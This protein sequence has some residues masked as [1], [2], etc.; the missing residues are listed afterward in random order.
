MTE[1]REEQIISRLGNILTR[2][3]TNTRTI[4]LFQQLIYNHYHKNPRILPWRKTR[5]PYKILVSEIMLQQTQVERVL[6]KYQLFIRMFPDFSSLAGA[7]LSDILRVWQG[8]GYNR[9]AIALQQIART[10]IDE[11]RG[12]L[13]ASREDLLKLPGV[14][15]YTASAL[16]TFIHNQPNIFIETNIRRVF[17]HFFYR[18]RENITDEEIIPLVEKTLDEKNPRDWYYALMD[19]GVLLKK[20]VINPNRRSAHYQKQP[21]FQGSDRQLRGLILKALIKDPGLSKKELFRKL[22]LDAER[23]EKLLSLLVKEGFLKKNGKHFRI[24]G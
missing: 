23:I 3:G 10:I 9:R 12:R 1:K 20:T 8:L 11:N 7:Q 5:N 14:G 22:A 2:K 21:P 17:I 15:A 19:Y 24:N 13:P 4:R 6:G 18:D 16:L